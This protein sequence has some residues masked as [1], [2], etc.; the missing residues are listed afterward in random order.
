[1]V[2]ERIPKNV[3]DLIYLLS[4]ALHGQRAAEARLSA[5]DMD[6][7]YRLTRM[8]SITAMAAV[9]LEGQLEPKEQERWKE[10]R[11]K[12]LRKNILLD[13]ECKKICAYMESAGIWYMPLKGSILKNLYPKMEMREMSDQDILFDAAHQQEMYEYMVGQGYTAD[14]VGKEHHDTYSKPPVYNIE[15]HHS[16]FE[17]GAD[18]SWLEYYENVKQ[19]LIP[20][21]PG[22]FGHH[23][24]DEDF[25]IYMHVHAYK[26]Y[27]FHGT[28]LRSIVDTYVY[29]MKKGGTMDWDYIERTCRQLRIDEYER[30]CRSLADKL[31]SGPEPAELTDEEGEMLSFCVGAGTYG[32]DKSRIARDLKNA[33]TE[34]GKLTGGAKFRYVLRRLF[35]SLEEM[36]L[37]SKMVREHPWTLP[38]GWIV[39]I[40]RGIF[41]KGKKSAN[42]IR[43]IMDTDDTQ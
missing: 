36:K 2:N 39:R 6:K 25:Y 13:M 27:S 34:D 38:L 26:H 33:R 7:M 12:A 21:T 11:S 35:P 37:K 40:F 28:G 41:V 31:F 14:E 29:N 18:L 22:S 15:L 32:S 16:L 10:A 4:C 43:T 5:I 17:N 9:A 1:M 20:D 24:S 30:C 42:E 3:W 23:F 19:R 8:N